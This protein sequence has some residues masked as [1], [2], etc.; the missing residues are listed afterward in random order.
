MRQLARLTQPKE[1]E[2]NWV[3]WSKRYSKTKTV[4]SSHVFRWATINKVRIN[5]LLVPILLRM[6]NNHCHYCD[7]FPLLEGDLTID[8]FCP[9]GR[10]EFYSIAYQWENLFLSCNHCQTCKME[11]Y[12]SDLLRPDD[13]NYRFQNYFI[14][15][16]STHELESNPLLSSI[17][18]IKVVKT[19]EVFNFNH[20]S[21]LTMRRH[22]FERYQFDPIKNLADYP[23]RFVFE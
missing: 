11:N 22:A 6:S 13:I 5:S 18:T 16:F 4:N 2:D 19:L 12:D 21:L 17:D 23:F 7:K 8:H 1:L 9:K 20:P 10:S 3:R 14:Y 15:N